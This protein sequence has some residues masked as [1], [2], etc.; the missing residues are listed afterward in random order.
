MKEV[1]E[2]Q[3]KNTNTIN[4]IIAD[5]DV[6]TCE[7]IKEKLSKYEQIK[8]LGIA[9]T[10]DEEIRLIEELNPD[11]VVTDLM[12]NHT[13]GGLD[14]IKDYEQKEGSPKFI[15]VSFAPEEEYYYRLKNISNF[16]HKYPEIT[17]TELVYKILCAKISILQEK[18]ELIEEKL[19]KEEEKKFWEKV[20]NMLIK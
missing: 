11:I 13:F 9:N 19:I 20:K 15:I 1:V 7:E 16:V 14:I 6:K 17:E 10:N 18:Q 3:S 4:I 2:K 8:I 5:D 12:R